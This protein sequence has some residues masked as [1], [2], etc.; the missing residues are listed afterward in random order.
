M[1][2]RANTAYIT[3]VFSCFIINNIFA[4]ISACDQK[5]FWW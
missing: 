4:G 5:Y 2:N 1:L 3:K